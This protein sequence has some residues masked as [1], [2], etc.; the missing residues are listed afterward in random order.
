LV[1]KPGR[2]KKKKTPSGKIAAV[3]IV[4][5]LVGA[6]GWYVY[7]NYIYKP[8]PIFARIDTSL[9][10]IDIELYPA[11]APQTVSNFVNLANS[12]FYENLVWHRIIP[13]FIIQT[14]DNNSRGGLNST[15][16]TWGEGGSKQTVPLEVTGC[17]WIG[18]YAGYLGMARRGN[19][20]VGLDTGTSQFFINLS[21]STNN[22]SLN[23]H[24]TA[25]GKVIS[26]MSVACTISHVKVY[27]SSSAY[28]SQPETPVFLD[29]VSIITS[30]QAP[31]PQ[32]MTQCS[33]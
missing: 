29:N 5:L 28:A 14:G 18:N 25:F 33:S 7:Q 21:N 32:Q 23:G 4:V 1:D 31:T 22:I 12:G 11:C 15:R 3:V 8:P 24:Y 10:V 2:R 17:S 19:N 26:G 13:G 9:G 20:T 16:G 30:A 6:I 27:P